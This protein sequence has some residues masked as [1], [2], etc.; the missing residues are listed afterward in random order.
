MNTRIRLAYFLLKCSFSTFKTNEFMQFLAKLYL[1]I[2]TKQKQ[3]QN[4]NHRSSSKL[5]LRDK[6]LSKEERDSIISSEFVFI[7]LALKFTSKSQGFF[8]TNIC[9]LKFPSFVYMFKNCSS[10]HLNTVRFSSLLRL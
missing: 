1:S 8:L 2:I 10:K 9:S 7:R 5:N 4:I 6:Y 3:E